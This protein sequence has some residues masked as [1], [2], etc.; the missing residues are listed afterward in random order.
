METPVTPPVNNIKLHPEWRALLEQE[1]HKPYFERLKLFLREEKK[2][3]RIFPPGSLIF[4]ALNTT[5]PSRIKVVILGQDPYHGEGQAHG[6]CFSVLP[7]VAQPPS[8]QNIFK[9]LEA[10]LGLPPPTHGCLQAWAERGVLLLNTVLTV[11]ANQPRSHAGKGWEVFTD[12]VLQ[13]VNEKAE[14]VCFMLWGR[15]ARS[16]KDLLD[17]RRHLVLEAAHPSPFSASGFLGCR[18]FSKANQWLL[19]QGIEPVDWSLP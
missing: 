7:G 1:F 11:R 3:Y 5:P 2:Q 18:H 15:D 17:T 9:E 10:D 19:E 8:L 16:K 13:A 4:N 6:L 12:A 14:P